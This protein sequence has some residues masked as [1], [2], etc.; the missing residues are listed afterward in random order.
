MLCFVALAVLSACASPDPLAKLGEAHARVGPP[1][2]EAIA[3]D[4]RRAEERV[5]A[6]KQRKEAEAEKQ[7]EEFRERWSR[8]NATAK[9]LRAELEA[10]NHE[11]TLLANYPGWFDMAQILKSFASI[12]H[13]E[14]EESAV[15]KRTI[16]L[17]QWSQKWQANGGEIYEKSRLL[18]NRIAAAEAPLQALE[19]DYNEVEGLHMLFMMKLGPGPDGLIPKLDEMMFNTPA[20][21]QP[22]PSIHFLG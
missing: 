16:A 7:G 18:L 15:R 10:I 17:T 11:S 1:S 12:R 21:V 13:L 20:I 14:G 9:E 8:W 6:E 4:M 19:K 5:K 22:N 2:P 3:A